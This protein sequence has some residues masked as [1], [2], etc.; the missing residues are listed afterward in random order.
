M[1]DELRRRAAE[2][3]DIEFNLDKFDEH[4]KAKLGEKWID[5]ADTKV[6]KS[7][8]DTLNFM[9][10][11]ARIRLQDTLQ[12]QISNSFEL[13]TKINLSDDIEF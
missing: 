3:R 2:W 1:S 11:D 12:K 5:E 4:I 8:Y 10:R 6:L 7:F 9:L 13:D